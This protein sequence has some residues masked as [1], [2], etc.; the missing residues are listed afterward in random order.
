M[1]HCLFLIIFML[2]HIDKVHAASD[3]PT[4]F[5]S[6]TGALSDEQQDIHNEILEMIEPVKNNNIQLSY[7]LEDIGTYYALLI[8]Q[9]NPTI[10]ISDFTT[11]VTNKLPQ[12]PYDPL[13]S[14]AYNYFIHTI[15]PKLYSNKSQITPKS[16][17]ELEQRIKELA[18]NTQTD[19]NNT[20]LHHFHPN[21]TLA[22]PLAYSTY[23]FRSPKQPTS[24]TPQDITDI[25]NEIAE[26]FTLIRFD[27]VVDMAAALEKIS[28]YY[29]LLIL[30]KH[31]DITSKDLK[32]EVLNFIPKNLPDPKFEAA[33]IKFEQSAENVINKVRRMDHQV[34]ASIE[35]HVK[36]MAQKAQSA[37]RKD[38]S[39]QIKHIAQDQAIARPLAYGPMRLT[40]QTHVS[41]IST[42]Q[43]HTTH[44]DPQHTSATLSPEE[45]KLRS[46]QDEI[47]ELLSFCDT[48]NTYFKMVQEI[49]RYY[50]FVV[51]HENPNITQK[52]FLHKVQS[53]FLPEPDNKDYTDACNTFYQTE[54]VRIFTDK[55]LLNYNI[56]SAEQLLKELA[57]DQQKEL[58]RAQKKSLL[59]HDPLIARP[60]AYGPAFFA[61]QYKSDLEREILFIIMH[62][63]SQKRNQAAI[64]I[65]AY[66]ALIEKQKNPTV[67]TTNLV[68]DLITSTF[69]PN[70][71]KIL[72]NLSP[73]I[74]EVV[75]FLY[76]SIQNKSGIEALSIIKDA[77]DG[78]AELVKSSS[79]EYQIKHQKLMDQLVS[80]QYNFDIMDPRYNF[81]IMD[82]RYNFDINAVTLKNIPLHAT[83]IEIQSFLESIF[84]TPDITFQTISQDPKTVSKKI[85]VTFETS[86]PLRASIQK[87]LIEYK[88]KELLITV[89][90]VTLAKEK[91]R[92]L[93]TFVA[94]NEL[95]QNFSQ[96]TDP[97]EKSAL[98]QQM[99][100][101]YYY[102][103]ITIEGLFSPRS[104]KSITPKTSQLSKIQ[105]AVHAI[106]PTTAPKQL[107][108]RPVPLFPDTTFRSSSSIF[109]N[110]TFVNDLKQEIRFILD[111]NSHILHGDE[112]A[113][114][115]FM[116]DLLEYLILLTQQKQPHTNANDAFNAITQELYAND[117]E[118][119]KWLETLKSD[120]LNNV[121]T[122][123]S[124]K[125]EIQKLESK[126]KAIAYSAAKVYE[127]KHK[128][129]LHGLLSYQYPFSDTPTPTR[130]L[131][132]E[133]ARM[134][135]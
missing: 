33:Y 113:E 6:S 111:Q 68:S 94:F 29:A 20:K 108:Q 110:T 93:G 34:Q 62:E 48:R 53:L 127:Q 26:I 51:L 82:Q 86:Q 67:T 88:N 21:Q 112:H 73:K 17:Q 16:M 39:L 117:R 56:Q 96:T 87:G 3:A 41:P 102:L 35:T 76:S 55:G 44:V 2:L 54:L 98:Q 69:L 71:T 60:L 28:Q 61:P 66:L 103:P 128:K 132:R 95:Q 74:V 42:Q 100:N 13:Y 32:K 131:T 116:S 31:N 122:L 114:D 22:R 72:I 7:L 89:P 64:K 27:S 50:A 15:L 99:K 106:H 40:P 57:F 78:V 85:L 125:G 5:T 129:P 126:L 37:L 97:A 80:Q 115:D 123:S 134:L 118:D 36:H 79:N 18:L 83:D 124:E 4:A 1:F 23:F 38:P 63:P 59:T 30:Q 91:P 49:G 77:E 19:K 119:L 92:N 70:H 24:T 90:I 130:T 58:K 105:Q 14:N 8:L 84:N 65:M 43:V 12:M 52:D 101:L 25:Q 121:H 9:K 107:P 11:E 45:L 47:T 120:V 109:R 75:D 81:D 135:L 10:N 104:I 133:E 46:I